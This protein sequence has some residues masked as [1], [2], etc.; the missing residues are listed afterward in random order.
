MVDDNLF[1]IQFPVDL[2][3]EEK[4]CIVLRMITECVKD[5]GRKADADSLPLEDE[6]Q[7]DFGKQKKMRRDA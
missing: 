3:G 2:M 1:F 7:W 5:R 4:G 6:R